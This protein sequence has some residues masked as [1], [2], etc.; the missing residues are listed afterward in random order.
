VPSVREVVLALLRVSL[1]GAVQYRASFLA[2]FA[3]GALSAVGVAAPLWVV[4]QHTSRLTGWS[5]PEAMLVTGFFM[6][7]GGLVGAL[8]EPNLSAVVEGVRTGALDYL[9]VK[10]PDAQLVVS[11]QRISPSAAW[12]AVAGVG[13]LGWCFTQLPLP[14]PL[15]A[16]AAGTLLVSGLVAMYGLWLL[17]I[18][19]SFWFVRVDNL[20]YLLGAV[21]DAGRWPVT[22][23]SGWVRWVMVT[24]IPV[25]V[26][27]SYP[28]MALLGR[29]DLRLAAGG[30]AVAVAL[31]GLSRLAWVGALRRYASASS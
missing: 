25:G 18:C 31:A 9:L 26:V 11:L 3:L 8:V 30:V 6:I 21:T 20:R 4:F 19:L 2:E 22:V 29:L 28:A 24:V 14:S 17:V 1:M 27:T 12:Q 15:A 7:F 16:L 13:V 5:L 10:P 23:Y